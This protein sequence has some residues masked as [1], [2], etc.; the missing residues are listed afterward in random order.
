VR[1]TEFV[2]FFFGCRLGED[3]LCSGVS[4]LDTSIVQ[5]FVTDLVVVTRTSRLWVFTVD[6]QRALSATGIY[7]GL[8][9]R[10]VG[11]GYLRWTFNARCRLWVFTVDFQRT[12]SAMSIY[13]EV[14]WAGTGCGVHR[15]RAAKCLTRPHRGLWSNVTSIHRCNW[16]HDQL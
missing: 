3:A 8:S 1:C 4:V 15:Y 12:L 13:C 10:V 11:Y 14:I 16:S 9:T 2:L 6:F 5:R 7:C